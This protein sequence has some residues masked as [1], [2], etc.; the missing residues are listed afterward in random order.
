MKEMYE[1]NFFRKMDAFFWFFIDIVAVFV[2]FLSKLVYDKWLRMENCV[3]KE[4]VASKIC[5]QSR[6]LIIGCGPFPSTAITIARETGAKIVAIDNKR[7]AVILARRYIAK[8]GL[9]TVLV[10][11]GDGKNFSV[12]DFDVIV[13]NSSVNPRREVLYNVFKSS[14]RNSVIV[15]REPKKL[16]DKPLKDEFFNFILRYKNLTI[17]REIDHPNNWCSYIVLKEKEPVDC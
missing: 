11:Y 7:L 12:K 10:C 4:I 1:K 13:I 3:K 9:K 6:V 14:K 8:L 17:K 5:E 2:P 16:S 15:C